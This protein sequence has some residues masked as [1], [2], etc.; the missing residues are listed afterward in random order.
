[1]KTAVIYAR[2]S[3][4]KQREASIEDQVRV[5][6]EWCQREGY[7]VVQ[8][9]TDYALSGRTDDRPSF[10]RMISNAGESD[11]VLVYMMDR[12][13]RNPYD[14]PFY[15]H[16]LKQRGVKLVSA[17]ELIPETAEGVIYEKILEGLAAFESAR[18]S[19][20]ITRGMHGN[21]LKCMT[22]G[23]R[24]FGYREDNQ[25]CYEIDP[26][27]APLVVE[28]YDRRISG[29]A[30][31]SIASDFASRGVM[32]SHGRPCSR[33]M[34]DR[35][36][37][38]EK[39]TGV[40][41]WGEVRVEDGMPAIISKD[42][43][44]MA[45][46]VRSKHQPGKAADYVLSGAALCGGCGRN[47]QGVSGYGKKGKKY[48]YYRCKDH[49]IKPIRREWLHSEIVKV[50]R[51]ILADETRVRVIAS[52][53]LDDATRDKDTQTAI[54]AAEKALQEAERGIN[55]L[56]QAL[57]TSDIPEIHDEIKRLQEQRVR[58][59]A[60]LTLL[61]EREVTLDEMVAFLQRGSKLDDETL[62]DA[63]VY[64][65]IVTDDDVIVTL[66]YDTSE[67]LPERFTIERVRTSE[68]WWTN[69]QNIRITY[70]QGLVLI[71]FKR[72]A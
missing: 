20:R 38:N 39:Y 62:L 64:Q 30:V 46:S 68:I 10:Q 26:E 55:N 35:M 44:D 34:I 65:V 28:A 56:V 27:T 69:S 70:Y 5:C 19:E 23:A 57:K 61:S 12:F 29:E 60:E 6:T 49:C 33:S 47:L 22:N 31:N 43:F 59:Q 25:G 52:T 16:E 9:Y 8:I 42:V 50:L 13:S 1:M 63:F 18:T 4:S 17:T 58:A 51:E 41:T 53:I 71:R 3:S 66:N 11:I 45:Q 40:Y 72:A 48:D 15:K 21:A 32:T 54:K 7:E 67:G 14:A 2:F 37:H 36:L 24:L